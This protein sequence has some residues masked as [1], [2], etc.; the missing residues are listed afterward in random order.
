MSVLLKFDVSQFNEII[1]KNG[2]L[3]LRTIIRDL[4][5]SLTWRSNKEFNK[6]EPGSVIM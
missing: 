6:Y 2:H 3:A 5:D 4:R 1:I